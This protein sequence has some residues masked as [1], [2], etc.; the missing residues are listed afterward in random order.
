[1]WD[2]ALELFL[3]RLIV[4]GSLQVTLAGGRVFR[5]GRGEPSFALRLTDPALPRRLCLNPEL[6]FG[7]AYMDGTLLI[8]GDDLRGLLA[9]VTRNLARDTRLPLWQKPVSE[10]RRLLRGFNQW[11]PLHR[12][13]SNVAHHYDL[14]GAL[15]DLFLDADKQYSCAYFRDPDMTLE[16]A[17]AAKK[18]HIAGKLLLT[19]GKRVLDI[20][21]GW[22]G[23]GLTL[24]RDYG[25]RV[26]GV[27]LSE[28]QLKVAQARAAAAGLSDRVE[29]RLMDYRKV[30]G[31]F[32]RIV[33]VGMFEHVGVP[34]YREYFDKVRALLAPDGVAL[35]HTIGR[36]GPPSY[37]NPWID[38]Y[39]FPG[40]YCPSLS[41]ITTA[42]EKARLVETDVEVWRLH[43]A[44]TLRHW[45]DRFMDRIDEARA[46]YDERFCRMWRFYLIGSEMA[47]V[48]GGHVVFQLQLARDQAA[49]PLTRDY[50][51]AAP[52]E[53]ARLA[54]AAE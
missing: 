29:F 39:I 14:S 15:Y 50:L 5:V 47:F 3:G 30:E 38:K 45:Y 33:S 16:E 4:D 43:Y 42:T 54:H 1:M 34:H 17:Q 28:E 46:L 27:T 10:V 6:A 48:N 2:R 13:K 26:L 23:L 32:D 52:P 31:P 44:R 9:L 22:G 24:A 40:G 20:G 18:A 53:R 11:N 25:A 37:T 35:I 8:E 12:A 36:V 21:C 7:E 49:V 19:P 51:Y 41:E